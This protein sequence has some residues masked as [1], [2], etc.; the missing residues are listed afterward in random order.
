MEK[1]SDRMKKK[2]HDP[3]DY[4]FLRIPSDNTFL[5]TV[6]VHI[7]GDKVFIEDEDNSICLSI[8]QAKRLTYFLNAR[9]VRVVD[10]GED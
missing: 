8:D 9:I 4:N 2:G 5:E 1:G 3:K 6:F 10:F 7:I